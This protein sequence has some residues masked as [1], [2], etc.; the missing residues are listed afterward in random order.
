MILVEEMIEKH[1]SLEPLQAHPTLHTP[2]REIPT[3]PDSTAAPTPR[4]YPFLFERYIVT[5]VF[6][7]NASL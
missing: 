2:Y 3:S 4:S 5:I 6:Q 1:G 7:A